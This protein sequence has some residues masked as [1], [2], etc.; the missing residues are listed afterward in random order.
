M[1]GGKK[2]EGEVNVLGAGVIYFLAT[3]IQSDQGW[4][5]KLR[6]PPIGGHY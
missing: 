1:V 2:K 5:G 4:K 3:S 6:S